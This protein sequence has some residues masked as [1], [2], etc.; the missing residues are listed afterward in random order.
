VNLLKYGVSR[1]SEG[2]TG[3]KKNSVVTHS[4][5]LTSRKS[6][7]STMMGA[8]NDPTAALSET[9]TRERRIEPVAV[10]KCMM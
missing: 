9:M 2:G 10:V 8:A 1:K 5:S 3:R 7:S 6:P 4:E